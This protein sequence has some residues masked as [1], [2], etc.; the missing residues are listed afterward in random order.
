MREEEKHELQQQRQRIIERLRNELPA[1]ERLELQNQLTDLNRR[2]KQINMVKAEQ[3][4]ANRA[5]R[6]AHGQLIF[7]ENEARRRAKES[8]DHP[9]YDTVIAFERELQTHAAA[10]AA[11]TGTATVR[12][13][14]E[15]YVILLETISRWKTAYENM[16]E[17]EAREASTALSEV[18]AEVLGDPFAPTSEEPMALLS[19][20]ITTDDEDR[21]QWI[22]LWTV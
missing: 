14:Q 18:F 10:Y 12:V 13:L 7:Q 2:I 4:A 8:T 6:R 19:E 20:A 16:C 9:A 1:T 21:R 11:Q 5:V 15:Q 17:I 22:K 3:D